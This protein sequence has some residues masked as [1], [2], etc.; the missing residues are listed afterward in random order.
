[1]PKSSPTAPLQAPTPS[2]RAFSL[3]ANIA[4][5]VR[6]RNKS[7]KSARTSGGKGQGY[8]AASALRNRSAGHEVVSAQRPHGL[9][10]SNFDTS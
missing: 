8:S 9:Q 3:F 5:R 4:F 2:K 7:S 6:R 10:I 1:M